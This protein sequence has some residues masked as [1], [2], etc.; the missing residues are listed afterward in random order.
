[1]FIYS[2]RATTIKFTAAI[3]LSAAV[4][5]T[6]IAFIPSA[7][8]TAAAFYYN[9]EEVN[10]DNIKTAQDR[11]DFLAGFGWQISP[12]P[13][14]EKT[15]TIPDEFDKVFTTYNELMKQQG[16]DL[17]KYSKKEVTLYT[18]KVENYP[19]YD[20]TVYANLLIYKNRVI[21]GD[22]CSADKDGFVHGFT[23]EIAGS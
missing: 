2:L 9:G 10:F 20:G 16:L 11:A 13:V 1:M 12:E 18:Y 15:V 22:I 3:L 23:K 7:E 19:D 21:A 6:L 4:L 17:S 14:S 8:P 5:I